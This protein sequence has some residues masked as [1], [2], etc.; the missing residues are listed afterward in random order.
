MNNKSTNA[1]LLVL[2]CFF[3]FTAFAQCPGN[4]P[5]D[6]SA[7][8]QGEWIGYVYTDYAG[9][10]PPTSPFNGTYRGYVT[11]PDNFELFIGA[12]NISGANL[13]GEYGDNFAVRFKMQKNFI[14]G[15]YTFYVGA[16]DGYRVSF[17]G[18]VTF[19][20]NLSSWVDH[21]YNTKAATYYMEGTVSIV[22]DYY[23]AGGESR[24][25][26]NFYEPV[27]TSTA[28]TQING[29]TYVSCN[30][31][32]TLYAAGGTHTIGTTY[33]W[34]TGPV[35][36][37]N[38]IAGQEEEQIT[39]H[40]TGN[41]T[42]WVRRHIG[43]P[44]QEYTEGVTVDVT[45]GTQPAGDPAEFG[46]NVWHVYAYN[47]I[48]TLEPAAGFYSGYYEQNS[49]G[50][51][52][53]SGPNGWPRN[54]SPSSSP[55]Y[56]GC[57]VGIDNFSFVHKRRGFP[58]GKYTL[59]MRNWDDDSRLYV[60]GQQVWQQNGWSGGDPNVL[61]GTYNLD[62]N[63]TIELRT[64]E[65]GG[66]ANATLIITEV[67]TVAPT[68]ISGNTTVCSGSAL[69]LTANGGSTGTGYAYQWG[70]GTPGS[71]IIAGHTGAGITVNPTSN[72]T[73]WV[74]V[75]NTNCG[76][77]SS[78]VT[79]AVTT[80]VSGAG[81]V[82]ASSAATCANALPGDISLSGNTG[83]IIKWQQADDAAFS[84]NV[85][86]IANTTAVLHGTQI[87]Q[88]AA[89]RYFRAVINAGACGEVVTPAAGITVTAPVVYNGS[90][91][92]TPTA[93]TPIIVESS[94]TLASDLEVCSCTVTGTAEL[95][96]GADVDF[97]V[98]GKVI[99]APT[100]SLVVTN[101]GSLIQIDDL[102]NEGKAEIHRNSSKIKRQDYTLWSSPVDGQ[103]L[104]AFSPLTLTTRFYVYDN[105]TNYYATTPAQGSFAT[106]ASYLIRTPN[107]HPVTATVY[108]GTFTGE[109]HNGD[110][111]TGIGYVD[112]AHSYN[113]VGNPYPSPISAAD[114]ID[115]NDDNIEGTLWMWRKTNDNSMPSYSTVTKFAYNANTAP[116]GEND[117]AHDPNGIINTGQ[118]FIVK[119]K[120]ATSV[121]FTNSMRRGGSTNQFFR[122]AQSTAATDVSR[123]WVSL[124]GA[125][126]FAQTVIGYTSAATTGYD[127]GLDGRAIIDGGV[128]VY[129]LSQN[130]K[131]AIQARPQFTAADV[132]S[133]GYKASTAGSY[134]FG[135]AKTDGLFAA[136]QV[137]YIKDKLT[138]TI[139][140]IAAN[141]YTFTSEAGTFENRFEVMYTNGTLGTDNPT[142]PDTAIVVYGSNS[143]A[144]IVSPESIK[145]VTVFDLQGRLIQNY[146]GIGKT[147]FSTQPLITNNIYLIQIKLETGQQITKK[148]ILN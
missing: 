93:E 103:Q 51:A 98:K 17:D 107:N 102:A 97:T 2:A 105:A 121:V 77:F 33:Q 39:V 30:Q 115:A 104:L 119:S 56:Q 43:P 135:I 127:N 16:D 144:N 72:T 21:G 25:N 131:L 47:G 65:G 32:T 106:G 52:T 1:I 88:L 22:F 24:V 139:H 45:T 7:Y 148:I 80:T 31:G 59:V 87:G 113:A 63:S 118:G 145:S 3:G 85:Q 35:I 71:N 122:V 125:A 18:G 129:S 36:G 19:V 6:Q 134:T 8:G 96:V 120:G 13:C 112:A 10:S 44:C 57:P 37:E 26:F 48:T 86:D 117:F 84:V 147:E 78:A 28:P 136:G 94:L 62:E 142:L 14:A 83:A 67:I 60:N 55:G 76:T 73:Y 123:V 95:T 81:T 54:A 11:Q 109:P 108:A 128:Y 82:A 34:G 99:V 50:F 141:A 42:Y 116:G 146:N 61:I 41:T 92:G 27:C 46:D 5:G 132:V 15:Y 38:V 66:D 12:G 74:R 100:A 91:S 126:T 140:N 29:N 138:N 101:N 58:C 53:D 90:W 40:P 68:S 130:D 79:H 69:G 4:P 23:E 143:R 124:S 49:L 20:N 111:T 70:T 75:Q 89:S 110:I 9:G 137:V 114:F 133:L 64:L